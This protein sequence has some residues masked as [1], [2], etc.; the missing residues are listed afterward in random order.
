MIQLCKLSSSRPC[1]PDLRV[2]FACHTSLILCHYH[3]PQVK[4]GSFL[5]GSVVQEFLNQINVGEEHP[6]T[7]IPL[8][9]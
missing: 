2:E 8:Q 5:Q 4:G 7:A 9:A 6:P 3:D 1:S